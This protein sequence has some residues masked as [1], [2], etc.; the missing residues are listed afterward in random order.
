MPIE[1]TGTYAWRVA[2]V[3]TDG[4]G[5]RTIFEEWSSYLIFTVF[6]SI[7]SRVTVM[8]EVR[9]GVVE[10]SVLE[11]KIGGAREDNNLVKIEENLVNQIQDKYFKDYLKHKEEQKNEQ[12]HYVR[13]PTYAALVEGVVRGEVDYAIGEITRAKYREQRGV[14]FTRGYHDALPIF[15]SKASTTGPP[16]DGANHRRSIRY[17][18]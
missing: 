3:D 7:D 5:N 1:N 6:R 9:V 8:N 4:K 13:Y 10:G 15:I 17:R 12:I 18:N 14:F 2:R 11:Q 16:G